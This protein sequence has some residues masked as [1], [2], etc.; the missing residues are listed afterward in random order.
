M[1]QLGK[2]RCLLGGR[3]CLSWPLW[4]FIALVIF[5]LYGY[6][7]LLEDFHHYKETFAETTNASVWREDYE[8]LLEP[9]AN[10]GEA[11]LLVMVMSRPKSR[12]RRK[13]IR[14]TWG[15]ALKRYK[16]QVLFFSGLIRTGPYR[17][18]L[19]KNLSEEFQEFGDILLAD[20]D[21]TYYNLALK[22]YLALDYATRR[23][24][25]TKLF[26]KTDDDTLLFS[27]NIMQYVK[28]LDYANGT[29]F[30]YVYRKSSVCRDRSE[31]KL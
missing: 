8:Y 2:M 26:L 1:R 17:S 18:N 4:A 3:K 20:F 27:K 12:T 15:A 9:S 10:D 22:S 7:L 30:C 11:D 21:D 25:R 31:G 23:Y 6:R 14:E 19:V 13:I 28:S 5:W 29:L 16:A 24:N